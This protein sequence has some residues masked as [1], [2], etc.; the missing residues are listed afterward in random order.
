MGTQ[1][2]SLT[3]SA[4]KFPV[5]GIGA[6]AGGLAAF[7]KLLEAIPEDSGMAYVL[8]QHLDPNHESLLPELLQKV[9]KIPVLEIADD[10]KVEPNH[11]YIIP[12]NKMLIAND[13]LLELSPRPAPQRNKRNLP[14][15]LFFKSLAEVHQTYSLGVVLS[16]TGFDGTAGL[17]AI[18]D[19]GGITFAQD[20]QSAE[21]VDMPKNAVE[22][23]VVDFILEPEQIPAKILELVSTIGKNGVGKEDISQQE[24]E[25]FRKILSLLRIRKN[26]DFTYY[27]QTTIHRRILRRMAINKNKK[28]ST[29]LTYLRE[30]RN[31]QDVLYQDLLIPVTSFFRDLDIFDNL[32]DWVMPLL[33]Q[34]KKENESIRLWAAGCSTGQ[35]A[36]SLV[37]CLKE[38]LNANPALNGNS[39]TNAGIKIQL[40]ATDISE[41]AIAKARKGIYTKGELENVS[42]AR[43]K[44]FFTKTKIGYQL[45]K[46]IREMCVFAV[47][48]FLSDPP[49][50]NMDIISCRNVLIYLQP[51]LQKKA[52]TTFHYSLNERGY[53]LLGK[54]ETN[55]SMPD[56]FSPVNKNDKLFMRKDTATSVMKPSSRPSKP[57]LPTENDI[58]PENEKKRTDFQKI[59]DEILL[60][61]FTPASVVVNE[62][63]DIVLFHGNTN[64][65]LGQQGG[66]PSHNLIKMAKGILAFELRN[67]IHKVKKEGASVTKEH[68]HFVE[69]DVKQIISLEA[70]PLPNVVE[71][72]YLILFH[73]QLAAEED[74][75][76]HKKTFKKDEKDLRILQLE[77]ELE[78]SLEDMRGITEDQEAANEELQS[79]NEELLS[80]SEELQSLNEELETSKEELQS[81]NEE[82]TIIN[83]ELINL[84]ELVTEER[85]YAEAIVKTIHEPLL[86]LD[87]NLK[88]ITAN[89]AFYKTFH[90]KEQET[91]GMLIYELGNK[92]WDIPELRRLLE[93]ILPK[94]DN[95]DDFEV[96]HTFENIGERIMRLNAKT[97]EREDRSKNLILLA[98]EDITEQKQLQAKEQEHLAKF[99]NLVMQ[100]P[101]AIMFLKGENHKVDLANDFYLQLVEKGK[102]FVGK[103]LFESLPELKD[104]GI[105][106]LLDN[107]L[108]SGEPYY[109]NELELK[110]KRDQKSEQGFYNFV[111]QPTRD[112]DSAVTGIMV[113]ATEVTEQVLARQKIEESA[114]RYNEMIHSSPSLIAI[115]EGKDLIISTA[116][117]AILESWGK[118]KGIIGKSIFEAIPETVEQGFDKL[119]LEVYKT[120][121]PIHVDE[122]PITL[123]RNGKLELMHYTFVYQAQRDMESNIEGVAIL[124]NEVT[125]QVMAKM[126]LAESEL[127]FHRMAELVPAKI[128]NAD[129]DGKVTYFNKQWLDFSGY[130]FEELKKFGYHKMMHPEEVEKFQAGLQQ[131]AETGTD[132]EM[133]MRFKNKDG[134]YVWHL[135]VAS[136]VKD[137]K[138]KINMWIGAATEIQKIKEEEKRKEDFLKM[139]SHELKTPVTSIKGYTQLLLSMLKNGDEQK[140][141]TIPL[142]PGLER[143]D[144]QVSRLTRLISEMLDLSRMDDSKLELQREIFSMNELVDYSVQDLK[145]TN[146][147]Y[148]I[149]ITHDATFSVDGDKDR[150]NQV[151]INFITN[152]I[153]YSPNDK[154]IKVRV[155]KEDGGN[156]A[157]SVKDKGIGIDEKD[158]EHLFKRFYRVSGKDESAFTGFGIGL[159]LAKEII[160]RHQGQVAVKS[161]KGK[162]SEFIFTLPIVPEIN[163][164]K[165]E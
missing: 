147:E 39:I 2:K 131:A 160:E 101:V 45:N 99:K 126:E 20:Q 85:N 111:Y 141:D 54:S 159:Y 149:K 38:Y 100:A 129:S 31:E 3:K 144:N 125:P 76:L 102:D 79:A 33:V 51:Y 22:A 57:L 72:H 116:N 73:R 40:F 121:T 47:H 114:Y 105:K 164:K 56:H 162:G 139:A 83:H 123:L 67:I 32:C 13:G 5:V 24:E 122:A 6:S 143:I 52:L 44:E 133:E 148:K 23:G 34:N 29:Y 26:T 93:I 117:D 112:Q 115:L 163:H 46:E 61:R 127:K 135:N 107:V 142:I 78:Q 155:Y 153:K 41:P 97:I 90:V 59:A 161:K 96:I 42:P 118:G 132:F 137:G 37:I 150:I 4:N 140:F 69:N 16:G 106:D 74:L 12:S 28:P 71:P 18:K 104:Q 60:S 91:E 87:K 124:A 49:F 9:T 145:Y 80:G 62:A 58:E 128:S 108:Q 53:L 103:P 120:G 66:K 65:Y 77:K 19:E 119:L 63:M 136:P 75:T 55:S 17:K 43:L 36:Y 156:G 11:I 98:I 50:G 15:D 130:T 89:N 14:I 94:K 82:I 157:V 113:I 110:M 35:E 92:Q 30:N 95:L 7:K 86:V 48:N 81:T 138:G 158:H 84:N 151:L 1:K 70:V 68:I 25:V 8:V 27:K 154:N 165:K 146:D 10:I 88:V 21:W 109:G 64:S 134:I 152:A